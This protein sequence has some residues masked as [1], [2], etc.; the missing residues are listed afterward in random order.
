[1]NFVEHYYKL[2]R[3]LLLW[4]GLWPYDTSFLK[5]IQIICFEATFISFLLCQ[6]NVFLLKNCSAE[7]VMKVLMFL[8]I[9]IFFIVQYN[10]GVLLTDS[11]KYIFSRLRYDWNMLQNQKE[12]DIIQKYADRTRFHTILFTLLALSISLGIIVLCSVPSLLD[13]IIPLN[14]SRPSWLPIVAEYFV[15]QQR[16]FYAI[17]IH[18]FIVVY[19]GSMAIASVAGMM[20]GYVLH[21][22]A[23]FKIASYRIEHIFDEKILQMSKTIGQ[24]V[25][26]E[27][28]IHAVH[29][30]RRAVDLTNDLNN[31]FSRICFIMI[32]VGM[33][34]IPFSVFHFF[35]VLA[36]LNDVLELLLSCGVLIFQ[37]YYMFIINYV[38]QD[39][40]NIS[41]NV[42]HT[43]YNTEWYAAPLWL[44]KLIL[45][46]LQRSSLKSTLIAGGIVDAS[47]EGFAKLMSMSMSYVMFLRSTR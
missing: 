2:N 22:C 8:F 42:F 1:M 39:I 12:F 37:L 26:Y 25:L 11:F 33:C 6:L 44:Q 9:T 36:P 24:Y 41:T 14:E 29:L 13:I 19:A 28:L 10:V 20:L 21:N 30:H 40:I 31:S 18:I 16:Y 38:G 43:A 34:C 46:I 5:K 23:I 32:I 35:Y 27:R 3:I 47:L 4:L 45:V 15:D 7:L 17:L